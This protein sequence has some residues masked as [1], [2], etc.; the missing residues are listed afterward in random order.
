MSKWFAMLVVKSREM[1]DI[2]SSEKVVRSSAEGLCHPRGRAFYQN[3]RLAIQS[4]LACLL[5]FGPRLVVVA[6]LRVPD[7][8]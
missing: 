3:R 1:V 2:G 6:L 4:L 5:R 7:S 8:F